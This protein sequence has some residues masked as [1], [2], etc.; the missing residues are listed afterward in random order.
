MMFDIGQRVRTRAQNAQGHTRLP[1]YLECRE[2]RIVARLGEYPFADERARDPSVARS[3]T[4]YT[5]EFE[6]NAH[7]VRADLFESYLEASK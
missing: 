5:V 3:E 4:L 7:A 6:Q 2:G 1:K